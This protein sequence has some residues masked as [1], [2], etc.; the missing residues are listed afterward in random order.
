MNARKIIVLLCKSPTDGANWMSKNPLLMENKKVLRV[1][2]T[3]DVA[4]LSSVP[5]DLI[6]PY[7]T[8]SF[9]LTPNED[10]LNYVSSRLLPPELPVPQVVFVGELPRTV[11][12]LD[13]HFMS[14]T[15]GIPPATQVDNQYRV[16]GSYIDENMRQVHFLARGVSI[17]WGVE[18]HICFTSEFIDMYVEKQDVDQKS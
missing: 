4:R 18:P 13:L 17:S 9:M 1:C 7:Q 14:D 10:L 16:F 12:C 3:E 5:S 2:K 15:S 11:Y 8:E 6:E